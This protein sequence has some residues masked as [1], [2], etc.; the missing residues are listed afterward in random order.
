M[1]NETEV[2]ELLAA[3]IPITLLMDLTARTPLES[4]EIYATEGGDAG[5]LATAV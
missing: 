4:R 2:M 1:N 5:W 3:G